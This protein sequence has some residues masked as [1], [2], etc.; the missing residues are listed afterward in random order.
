MCIV[1]F[2]SSDDSRIL[3]GVTARIHGLSEIAPAQHITDT[4][5]D[6]QMT[7]T[8]QYEKTCQLRMTTTVTAAVVSRHQLRYATLVGHCP[9]D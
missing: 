6:V 5:Y 7:E 4:Q 2:E 9:V 1:K 3:E 8:H